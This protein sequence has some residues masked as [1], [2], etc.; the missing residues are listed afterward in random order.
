MSER[1]KPIDRMLQLVHA[2][3]RSIEGL[4]LDEMGDLVGVGR[5]AV[6]RTRNVVLLHF[7]LDEIVDG[8]AKR[9]RIKDSPGR[10]YARPRAEEVAALQALVDT[11]WLEGAAQGE[12]LERLLSRI[13]IGLRVRLDNDLVLLTRLQ[14]SRVAAGPAIEALPADLAAILSAMRAGRCVEFDYKAE[15]AEHPA[16]RR[17]VP[18]GLVH[19]LVTYLVGAI[20]GHAHPAVMYRLDRMRAVSVSDTPGSVAAGW[21]LDVWLAQSFGIWCEEAHDIVLRIRPWAAERARAWR[22]HPDQTV[23][24]NGDDLLVRFKSGGWLELAN[25]LFQWAD[26]WLTMGEGMASDV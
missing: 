24:A 17:V 5:R 26:P 2:L 18:H 3:T 19:G 6:E 14:R 20:P 1:L 11:A 12:L 15:R 21:D 16:W 25:H 13:K 7:D 10:A 9:F 23:E 22:F 4:T 8:R